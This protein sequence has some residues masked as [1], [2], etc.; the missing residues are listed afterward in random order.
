V[1][2]AAGDAT[3][4]DVGAEGRY[5]MLKPKVARLATNL[6]LITDRRTYH[7][8]Y[9]VGVTRGI[10]PVPLYGLRF[11]YPPDPTLQPAVDP[12]RVGPERPRNTA[13]FAC[14]ARAIRPVAAWDD[15][16]QLHLKFAGQAEWPAVYA[17]AEDGSESLV[18]FN[19][20]QDELVVHRLARRFVLRR[21]S[22]RACI[23]NRGVLADQRAASGTVSASVER[24]SPEVDR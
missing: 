20:E 3:A 15:G 19:V 1:S 10:S 6:T 7:F 23:E 9:H 14:G 22:L 18:N 8:D 11:V 13:Y 17:Q 24:R 21:G 2:V 12:R 16:L 5:V 4:I